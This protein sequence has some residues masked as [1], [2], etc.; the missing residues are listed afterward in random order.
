MGRGTCAL[1]AYRREARIEK[2]ES[3]TRQPAIRRGP[4]VNDIP[5]LLLATRFSLLSSRVQRKVPDPRLG[6]AAVI[7]GGHGDRFVVGA[8][9]EGNLPELEQGFIRDGGK[10]EQRPDGGLGAK[11]AAAEDLLHLLLG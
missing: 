9:L 8:G 11:L 1:R 6:E 10:A 7:V 2:R 5:C 3:R 4:W